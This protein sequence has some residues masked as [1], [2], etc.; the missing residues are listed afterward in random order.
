[1]SV[2]YATSHTTSTLGHF[3]LLCY[4]EVR[5]VMV[6]P[7]ALNLVRKV[8]IVRFDTELW[9]RATLHLAVYG[10]LNGGGA[11]KL[12]FFSVCNFSERFST[13]QAFAGKPVNPFTY[14]TLSV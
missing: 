7:E 13:W 12:N 10:P 6:L 3:R 2:C 8:G 9:Y 14:E 4:F 5:Y 1:M 11:H